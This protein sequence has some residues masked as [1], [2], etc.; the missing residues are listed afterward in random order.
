M[1]PLAGMVVEAWRDFDRVVEC[2]SAED[3]VAQPDGQS[4]I[5]LPTSAGPWKHHPD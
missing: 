4:S 3:G 2:V 1:D 5:A